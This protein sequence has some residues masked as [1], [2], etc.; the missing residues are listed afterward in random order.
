[1][2]DML[3]DATYDIVYMICF[4][5]CC[6][7]N[8]INV[9]SCKLLAADS[10]IQIH[11]PGCAFKTSELVCEA[12]FQD[13]VGINEIRLQRVFRSVERKHIQRCSEPIVITFPASTGSSL[14]RNKY[15]SRIGKCILN[16][17]CFTSL[18]GS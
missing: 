8:K 18:S 15:I 2:Y 3:I 13:K 17:D 7:F 10:F 14:T 1:M 9:R 5:I 4:S 11:G 12:G 6:A 16:I